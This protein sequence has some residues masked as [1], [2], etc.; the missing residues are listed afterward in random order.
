[1]IFILLFK[2]IPCPIHWVVYLLALLNFILEFWNSFSSAQNGPFCPDPK[3]YK[4]HL[5]CWEHSICISLVLVVNWHL[6]FPLCVQHGKFCILQKTPSNTL[7]TEFA[8]QTRLPW[9]VNTHL[10]SNFT[11]L[12]TRWES[13]D[14]ALTVEK[15]TCI[16]TFVMF[17]GNNCLSQMVL[18]GI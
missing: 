16:K 10:I 12:L 13:W 14:I 3:K 4:F 18:F 17:M 11:T 1:M 2:L 8:E 9:C 7:V 6:F 15:G 5:N